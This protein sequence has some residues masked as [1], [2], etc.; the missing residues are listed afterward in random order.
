MQ[1]KPKRKRRKATCAD[2]RRASASVG[3]GL[4]GFPEA[5]AKARKTLRNLFHIRDHWRNEEPGL[6]RQSSASDR[7]VRTLSVATAFFISVFLLG[8]LLNWI[9]P[10]GL[11]NATKAHS[12]RISARLMAPFYKSDAQD[13]IAVVLIDES[14]LHYREQPWPPRYEYYASVVR[15][16]LYESPRAVYVDIMTADQ[17][18][19]DA[20]LDYARA[21]LKET[22][23]T[24]PAPVF[25]G[26]VSPAVPS[27]FDQV[28]GIALATAAWKGAGDGYPMIIAPEQLNVDNLPAESKP[29]M[30]RATP[31]VALLLYQEA[32]IPRRAGCAQDARALTAN[33]AAVP[34]SVHWGSTKAAAPA[35][36]PGRTGTCSR[37]GSAP[38]SRTA[39]FGQALGSAWH[40]FRSGSDSQRLDEHRERCPYTLTVFEEELDDPDVA[41]LLH[42]RIVLIGGKLAGA[43][44]S[45]VSPV[46]QRLPGVYLHAMALD[47]L[48]TW[49][50]DR[51]HTRKWVGGAV[52]AVAGLLISLGVA[53]A[54]G[55]AAGLPRRLM[56]LGTV[57]VGTVGA[58][59]WLYHVE[60]QP[61]GDWLGLLALCVVVFT[62]ARPQRMPTYS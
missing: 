35:S 7:F 10:F 5:W 40:S 55:Y 17:R 13:R 12:A 30:P 20:S 19:Y 16:V 23:V 39:R 51:L 31:S 9:E 36:T 14:T 15:R 8:A 47:N 27:L 25:W 2:C 45:V 28:P 41:A 34:L 32:C 4:V 48:M 53:I 46:H 57:L 54:L 42:D 1:S 37:A 29:A 11:D 62:A 50:T 59:V 43:D 61:P 21:S 38:P 49:G 52:M 18:P 60:R 44:D 26:T 22:L 58:S 24:D 6:I 33:M 56:L 3:D